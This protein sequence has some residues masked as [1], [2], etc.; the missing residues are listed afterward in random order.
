MQTFNIPASR[1]QSVGMGE[2]QLLDPS[3]PNSGVNRRVEVINV[4]EA[5]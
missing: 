1:L 3:N 2:T 5:G 4:G